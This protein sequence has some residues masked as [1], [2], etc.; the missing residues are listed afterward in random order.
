MGV[1]D[2][3]RLAYIGCLGLVGIIS[4][5]FGIIGVLP[6]IAEF[7]HLTI[8]EAGYLLSAFAL[9]IALTGPFM[10]LY[11]SSMNAKK[12]MMVA[13]VLFLISNVVSFFEPPF[14]ILLI[15]RIIP[16]F[17]Q[18]V[19]ISLSMAAAAKDA[20]AK[21]QIRNTGIIV[22]GIPIAQVTT[23]PLATLSASWLGWN[24]AYIIQAVLN[25]VVLGLLYYLMPSNPVAKSISVRQQVGILKKKDFLWSVSFNFFLIAAW[26]SSYSYFAKYLQSIYSFGEAETGSLLFLFG[27]MGII[28]NTVASRFLTKSMLKT[29]FLV[30]LGTLVFPLIMALGPVNKIYGILGVVIWGLLYGPCF[31][32]AI[33]LMQS[34]A[35]EAKSFSNT[36]QTSFGNLGISVGTF[37]SGIAM[38][39]YGVIS[40]PW[41]GALFGIL[42]LVSLFFRVR[43]D[44]KLYRKTLAIKA[45]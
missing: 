30:A 1:K 22:G 23:I 38:S 33:T 39:K 9:V 42:A 4:T 20:D 24:S 28:A 5:E 2:S 41:V 16:A 27:I 10:M 13:T 44:K 19:F 32:T 36:L 26:F 18:P 7:Y 35:T 34:A 8:D 31:I 12:V 43:I 3:K 25:L 21:T 14:N 29:V 40:S 45:D 37:A 11:T 15:L 17:L 6:Q